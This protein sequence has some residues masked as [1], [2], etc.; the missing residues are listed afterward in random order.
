MK[1]RAIV[2][3]HLVA[4]HQKIGA[5]VEPASEPLL[6]SADT[7]TGRGRQAQAQS[8]DGASIRIG[9]EIGISN[10]V[11]TSILARISA[12]APAVVSSDH[13]E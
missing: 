2:R 9:T 6:C 13:V 11:G 7:A 4:E 8:V 12:V 1:P 3:I 5:T 10:G